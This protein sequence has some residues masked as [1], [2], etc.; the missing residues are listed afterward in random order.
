MSGCAGW[1]S[2][3]PLCRA[4]QVVGGAAKSIGNDVFNSIAQYFAGVASAAVTWLWQQLN[5]ATA[6]DLTSPGIRA[7]LLATGTIAGLITTTLFLVQLIGSV[8]RQEPGGLGRGVRGLGICFIG[9]AFAVAATQV[10]LAAVDALC[11]GVVEFAL[12]TDL[13]GMGSKLVVAATLSQI[14]NPAGLLLISLVLILAVVIIWIALMIRKMLIIISAVFAPVAF[15][16]APHD[17]SRAWVRRW[18]EVT[19]ALVFSKLILVIIFMIGLSVLNG[20]GNP[21]DPSTTQAITSLCIGALTLLLAG[22][23]PWL[24]VKM[25]HFAGDAIQAVH[26][27]ATSATTGGRSAAAVPQKVAGAASRPF[28]AM[29]S[30]KTAGSA[31]HGTRTAANGQAKFVPTRDLAMSAPSARSSGQ[32]AG[33]SSTSGASVA[34]ERTD[35]PSANGTQSRRQS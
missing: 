25:V 11:N 6:I 22:F 32:P 12:N 30:M 3:N 23:A 8:L 21:P 2:V 16:G 13:R 26:V 10:V 31:A 33:S 19:L 18:I 24:A 1:Q 27:Q 28:G 5:I 4:G 34:N 35:P 7:D 29:A 14:T 20:A 15:A 9:A 17:S